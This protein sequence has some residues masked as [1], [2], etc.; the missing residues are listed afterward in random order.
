MEEYKQK[1]EGQNRQL[2]HEIEKNKKNE[3]TLIRQSKII[4]IGELMTN[5]AHH[6]RQPLNVLSLSLDE[7]HEH[8]FENTLDNATFSS[9]YNNMHL[10]LQTMSNTIDRFRNFF[11]QSEKKEYFNILESLDEL[12]TIII[13]RLKNDKIDFDINSVGLKNFKINSYKNELNQILLNLIHN[14]IEAI[15]KNRKLIGHYNGIVQ[16]ILKED[17]KYLYISILDNGGGIKEEILDKIFEPY[18]TTKFQAE[19]TGLGLYIN[20]NIIEY[21]FLGQISAYNEDNGARIEIKL[22]K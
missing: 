6:W 9:I 12:K 21:L 19:G 20:K 16:I 11:K 14:S 13:E 7:L 1:I 22:P 8:Y 18:F 5:I 17:E 10:K 4:L 15:D 3:Q 2:K